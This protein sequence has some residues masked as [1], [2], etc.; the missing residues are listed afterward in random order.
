MGKF[1]YVVKGR[2]GEVGSSK[3]SEPGNGVELETNTLSQTTTTSD[4]LG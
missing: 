1:S 4:G 3:S 2:C